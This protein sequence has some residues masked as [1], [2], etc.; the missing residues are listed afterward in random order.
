MCWCCFFKHLRDTASLMRCKSQCFWRERKVDFRLPHRIHSLDGTHGAP[1]RKVLFIG[2]EVPQMASLFVGG[3]PENS[4]F[5]WPP[6]QLINFWV[7]N[8]GN[9]DQSFFFFGGIV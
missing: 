6:S 7:L 1:G 3:L 9:R 2:V 5:S 4:A 8:S